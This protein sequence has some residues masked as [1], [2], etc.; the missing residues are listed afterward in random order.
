MEAGPFAQ[1]V[2]LPRW[3]MPPKRRVVTPRVGARNAP[4]AET[5][6]ATSP[7]LSEWGGGRGRPTRR[8]RV[9]TTTREPMNVAAEIQGLRQVVTN[10][11]E[12]LSDRREFRAAPL[13]EP[14]VPNQEHQQPL[15]ERAVTL[16]SFFKLNL[17]T[18]SANLLEE[19]PQFFI[20]NLNKAF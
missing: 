15:G 18:F 14:N 11:V 19:D 6:K 10:L 13:E 7:P 20:D 4:N 1:V 3:K 2:M 16:Q 5:G 8:G 12:S 9:A 17:P